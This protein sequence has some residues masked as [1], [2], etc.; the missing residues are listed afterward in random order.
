MI[1]FC[2]LFSGSS[3]NSLYIS[4]G[5]T[6]ILID[7]G[8]SGIRIKEAL[9]SI[10]E[11]PDDL[12]AL[13]VTHEH[14]DH[15]KCVGV[16]TRRYKIPVYGT[17]GT[18]EG[19]SGY[20]GPVNEANTMF[21]SA[22]KDFQINTIK[23][24]PFSIPHDARDPVG[25][26]FFAEGKKVTVATDIGHMNELLLENIKNSDLL[27]L[28]SNH[29]IEMLDNGSYPYVLKKRIKSD[30]GHLCNN[31]A[32]ETLA[33]LAEQGLN[34]IVIGHLSHENNHPDVAYETVA[35]HIN[36][37][38]FTIGESVELYVARRDETSKVFEV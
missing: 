30:H 34:K 26:S 32:G 19:M 4:D 17:N 7:A 3:G 31:A 18:W 25:F 24:H 21:I 23:V 28:E 10:G 36:N 37:N 16:I 11:N 15:T 35:S 9:D 22:N 27:M 38:G 33:M 1:K 12:D 29:D 8:V 2:S 5:K 14:S 13:V 20:I 6:R